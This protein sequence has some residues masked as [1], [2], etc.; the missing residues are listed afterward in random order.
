[1]FSYFIVIFVSRF[2]GGDIGDGDSEPCD[3]FIFLGGG[4]ISSPVV[5]GGERAAARD[6]WETGR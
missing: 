3:R 4:G 5:E 2:A 6:A 1:M